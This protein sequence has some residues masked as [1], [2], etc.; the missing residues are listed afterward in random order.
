MFPFSGSCKGERGPHKVPRY[1][2]QEPYLESQRCLQFVATVGLIFGLLWAIVGY[3]F[4]LRGVPGTRKTAYPPVVR[5]LE[6]LGSCGD[7]C[8][9]GREA[10]LSLFLDV[11]I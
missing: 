1:I 7:P 10:S 4:G 5:L 6:A 11:F 3:Y 8:L 9:E 2:L